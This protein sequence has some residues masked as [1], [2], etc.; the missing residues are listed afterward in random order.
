MRAKRCT[1]TSRRAASNGRRTSP[2][3][4]LPSP[5]SLPQQEATEDDK[6]PGNREKKIDDRPISF[7][8]TTV[9][10]AR[11]QT[12]L[13]GLPGLPLRLLVL[14]PNETEFQKAILE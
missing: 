11:L 8:A 9:P 10:D 5:T 13:R 4:Q 1:Q 6:H 12:E 7:V 14:N 2:G 3:T